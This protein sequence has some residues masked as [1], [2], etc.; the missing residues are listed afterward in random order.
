VLVAP[1]AGPAWVPLLP[2]VSAVVTDAGAALSAV[3]VAC[4]DLGIP[5]VVATVDATSRIGNGAAVA[6]DGFAG[7]V[8]LTGRGEDGGRPP[9]TPVADQPTS[10][11]A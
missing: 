5:C 7:T 6:V 1:S 8:R 4:R 3:A 9:P 11:S 2:A 10:S